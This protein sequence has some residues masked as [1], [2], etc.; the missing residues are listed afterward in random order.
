MLA[1]YIEEVIVDLT[2]QDRENKKDYNLEQTLDMLEKY[3]IIQ[4]FEL[5]EHENESTFNC[6]F[7][8]RVLH[9][10]GMIDMRRNHVHFDE[11]EFNRSQAAIRAQM[12]EE[13]ED[14]EDNDNLILTNVPVEEIPEYHITD[15]NDLSF[16]ISRDIKKVFSK[17]FSYEKERVIYMG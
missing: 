16:P 9:E 11:D 12:D 10:I 13:D 14:N 5:N 3:E 2:S 4:Q 1:P 7:F 15:V 17:G 6:Q 8:L